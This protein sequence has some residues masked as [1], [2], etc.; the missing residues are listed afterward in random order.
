MDASSGLLSLNASPKQPSGVEE[1]EKT[2][3]TYQTDAV[4][5]EEMNNLLYS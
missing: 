2:K 3:Q 4:T 5:L 1:A